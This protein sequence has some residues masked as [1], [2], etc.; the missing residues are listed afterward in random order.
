MG[1][2]RGEELVEGHIRWQIIGM[3]LR[4][5]I[6]LASLARELPRSTQPHPCKRFFRVGIRTE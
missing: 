4:A 2:A 3:R 5:S 6:L 1:R